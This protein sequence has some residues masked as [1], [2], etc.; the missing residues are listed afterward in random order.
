MRCSKLDFLLISLK[1]TGDIYKPDIDAPK[2]VTFCLP[3]LKTLY[4]RLP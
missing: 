2:P 1:K 3:S 4:P